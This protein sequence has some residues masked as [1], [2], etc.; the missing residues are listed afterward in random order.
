M[1]QN[2]E[3]SCWNLNQMTPNPD[4]LKD[5][6]LDLWKAGWAEHLVAYRDLLTDSGVMM[7]QI[8]GMGSNPVPVAGG[9][10]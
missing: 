9:V 6:S 4:Y 3:A 1:R 7:S 10:L 5:C 8:A 2:P